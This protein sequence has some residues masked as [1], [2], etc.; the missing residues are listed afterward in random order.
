MGGGNLHYLRI[1][2]IARDAVSA[3][4]QPRKKDS[5]KQGRGHNF[6]KRGSK[7]DCSE[8]RVLK[9]AEDANNNLNEMIAI[10]QRH[11]QEREKKKQKVAGTVMRVNSQMSDLRAS[12]HS[13]SK[14]HPSTQVNLNNQQKA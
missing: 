2:N 8:E 10:N 11:D 12:T 13:N 14:T 5:P 9:M 7:Y 1:Q 4:A 6:P 3:H